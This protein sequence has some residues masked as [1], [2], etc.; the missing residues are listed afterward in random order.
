M[1]QKVELIQQIR[2]MESVPVVRTK[3][4]DQT[5]TSGQGLLA[6]MSL[7]EVHVLHDSHIESAIMY[8]CTSYCV[9]VCVHLVTRK[10]ELD[11]DIR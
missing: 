3:F 10:T 5:E 2:A 9:C 8:I 6:E 7:V 11:E 4:I 1:R